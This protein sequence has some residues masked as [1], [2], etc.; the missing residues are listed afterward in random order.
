VSINPKHQPAATPAA[1]STLPQAQSVPSPV[2]E[3]R[4]ES[5]RNGYLDPDQTLINFAV[6]ELGYSF[7]QII[8]EDPNRLLRRW[9]KTY[10]TAKA[11][12]IGTTAL[13]A[14]A[15]MGGVLTGATPLLVVG[16]LV[17]G[18]SGLLVKKHSA[19]VESCDVEHEVLDECRPILPFLTEL[20]RRGVNPSDLVSLYDRLVKRVSA[21]PG[22]FSSASILQRLFKEEV[23][24]SGV[25]AQVS[26]VE[27]G[28]ASVA[29]TQVQ[30]GNCLTPPP[31][32]QT[33]TQE[34]GIATRLE[35]TPT[36]AQPENPAQ[37]EISQPSI[38]ESLAK[39]IQSS[40]IVGQPGAGKGMLLAMSIREVKRIHPDIQI[41]AIDPKGA[42]SEAW[43][44]EPCDRYLPLKLD[45]FASTET[46]T[47]ATKKCNSFLNQ[48]AALVGQPK[49][50]I[51]DEALFL[52]EKSPKWFKGLMPA[53]NGMCSIGRESR[54]YGWLV[55]Q[56]PNTDDFGIS[57]ALRN[58]YRRIMILDKTNLGLIANGST[59]FSGKPSL[60]LLAKTGRVFYDSSVDV[61][62]VMP[63]WTQPTEPIRSVANPTAEPKPPGDSRR[64]MLERSLQQE[65]A[66]ARSVAEPVEEKPNLPESE[67][68]ALAIE[69]E[70]WL[71][72]KPIV[73][74]KDY[75][76]RW[77]AHKRGLS[78]PQF[79]YLLTLIEG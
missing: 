79:R 44:W 18:S 10:K 46:I 56:S 68:M 27:T 43:R 21:N 7:E 57:G 58:V 12:A 59:Y 70:E 78:R 3:Q 47:E 61:W 16:V 71:A 5:E 54:Q 49:L 67:I 8:K 19:G 50:L 63:E 15:V 60:E 48:F 34:I 2:I 24:Q 30:E 17:A 38:A 4:S 52:K 55:S 66:P 20:E 6:R 41:W 40:L 22:R 73:E 75:Y 9:G 26:G 35:A 53:F 33:N 69:L 13:G 31:K 64:L 1:I 37:P 65:T 14:I 51:I 62:D 25:L 29:Q 77:N 28:L 74:R 36:T 76:T 39:K 32:V 23:E 72:G 45:P 42:K 11:T